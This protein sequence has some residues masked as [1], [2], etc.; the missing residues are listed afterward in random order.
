[1]L[2]R[3]AAGPAA[4]TRQDGPFLVWACLAGQG[5]ARWPA[6]DWRVLW[7]THDFHTRDLLP[8]SGLQRAQLV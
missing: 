4:D 2:A 1:M 3:P 5:R 6:K 8:R 7:M